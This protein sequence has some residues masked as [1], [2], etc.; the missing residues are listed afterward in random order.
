MGGLEPADPTTRVFVHAL[1]DFGLVDGRNIVIER[2]SAEGQPSRFPALM[3]EMVK[4]DV[5]VIVTFGSPGVKAALDAT[6]RIPIVGLIDNIL[7][8]GF[9]GTLDK[10]GH[11]LTGVSENF[12]ELDGKRL[13]LLKEAAPSIKRVAV[14]GYRANTNQRARWRATFEAAAHTLGME[15][16]WLDVDAPDDLNPA[17]AVIGRE[18]VDALYAAGT[19]VNYANATRIADFALRLGL[20]S[21]GFPR[22]GML[23]TYE[24]DFDEMVARAAGMVKKLL[25][26]AKPGDLPFEQP[27]K[28]ELAINTR[29]A[30]ALGLAIP[31]A[32]LQQANVLIE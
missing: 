32:M 26:G 3:R 16:I 17:F 21:F 18:R 31:K 27:T 14:L 10:P 11:N 28:F 23:L 13:Q 4:L 12:P 30:K 7:E 19:H 15:V 25:D 2:R 5:E 8:T 20:P 1:R 29:T 9:I 24:A 6:D 22:A